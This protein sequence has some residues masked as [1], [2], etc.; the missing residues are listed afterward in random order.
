VN[1]LKNIELGFPHLGAHLSLGRSVS[2]PKSMSNDLIKTTSGSESIDWSLKFSPSSGGAC[3]AN[4]TTP[5]EN[6]EAF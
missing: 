5:P 6:E 3:V 4:R 2:S 1:V